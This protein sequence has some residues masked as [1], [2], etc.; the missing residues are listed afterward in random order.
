MDLIQLQ[1]V[2]DRSLLVLTGLTALVIGA[3][4]LLR[5]RPRLLMVL[6]LVLGASIYVLITRESGLSFPSNDAV[7]YLAAASS[8]LEGRGLVDHDGSAYV[9]WPPLHPALLALAGAVR[10]DLEAGAWWLHLVVLS[11]VI[12]LGTPAG[13]SG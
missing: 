9:L 6:H 4:F 3:G 10:G 13:S 7:S 11:G 1:A 12:L 2:Y 8:L 5:S